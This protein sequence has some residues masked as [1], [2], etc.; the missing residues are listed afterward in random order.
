MKIS[1]T[2]LLVSISASAARTLQSSAAPCAASE[3]VPFGAGDRSSQQKAG[4]C[5]FVSMFSTTGIQFL[6]LMPSSAHAQEAPV[7]HYRGP[8]P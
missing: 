4:H 7:A 8:I 1:R 6:E 2:M 3:R 5:G